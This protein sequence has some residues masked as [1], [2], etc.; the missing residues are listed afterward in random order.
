MWHEK[1]KLPSE[2]WARAPGRLRRPLLGPP[3]PLCSQW[4]GIH[5]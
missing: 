4:Q 2:L 5:V 3:G 1:S